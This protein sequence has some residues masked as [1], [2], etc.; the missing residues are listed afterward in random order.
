MMLHLFY[1]LFAV[2]VSICL[3]V[4]HAVAE[5]DRLLMI[6][7]DSSNSMW[8]EL[9][10]KSR[11]YEAGRKAVSSFL[12]TDFGSRKIAFRAYGHRSKNDCRDTQLMVGFSEADSAKVKIS[13]AI[14]SLKPI[15]KTPITYSLTEAL[16]DF[17]GRP[18]DILLISD[19]IETC[20]ADPC[21]LMNEWKNSNVDIRVH[22]VGVGLNK[23]ER[24][25]LACIA[26]ESGGTYFDADSADQFAEVL[27]EAGEAIEQASADG[28]QSTAGEPVE[29]P[30]AGE[31]KQDERDYA[32]FITGEDDQGRTY[33]LRGDIIKDGQP[34][35][36]VYSNFRNVVENAGDYELEVGPVLRDGS[37]YKP[38]MQAVSI[39]ERGS[40]T[41]NVP[42]TPPA[43]VKARFVQGGE[44]VKGA[45]VTAYQNG[46]KVF[47]MRHFDTVLARPGEYEFRSEPNSDN[48]LSV[49][50]TLKAGE[51]T[52][53]VFDLS[54]TIRIF[55]AY[56]LPNGEVIKRFSE[57]WRDGKKIYGVHGSN[58]AVIA[59]GT[60]ELHSVDQRTPL[61]PLEIKATEDGETIEVPLEVGFVELNYPETDDYFTKPDR[62]TFKALDW[63][64][65][66][67]VRP[68]EI[69]PVK[70]GKYRVSGWKQAGYFEDQEVVVVNGESLKINVA[71]LAT[72]SLVVDYATSDKY[73][74]Q[75]DRAFVKALE[76]QKLK[77]SFLR[78]GQPLKLL[79]GRYV[80]EG[81]R[82]AGK[83]I[84][85]EVE[86]KV[87][88]T[89]E[90]VLQPE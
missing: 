37:I 16:K 21:A 10:D 77:K 41:F 14:S 50:A 23:L 17:N 25:A 72:G 30:E 19:G 76:G 42:V 70:P 73:K 60:Y 22:V 3:F 66:F 7:Y 85:Q 43:F 13:Q 44:E 4:V 79:P 34:L 86:V 82:Q 62:A 52:T 63:K 45:F 20:D 56:K 40:T 81:W 71:P 32:F 64:G 78:L 33:K 51:E 29:E 6:T 2:C 11:K 57:L 35:A 27:E 65:S 61:E 1:R 24:Q 15:G 5:E 31:A 55:F 46:E 18:G 8:G 59:P 36:K 28:V 26:R 12:N 87:G 80:V 68:G 83:I 84:P 39:V 74:R 9:A 69:T 90:I 67:L 53:V 88:R 58:G 47:G 48:K 38:V 89:A 54:K 75:P 49:N